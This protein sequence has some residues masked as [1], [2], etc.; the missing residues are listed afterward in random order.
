MGLRCT[1]QWATSVEIR[2]ISRGYRKQKQR[3]SEES[4][5]NNR[6]SLIEKD[7]K[8]LSGLTI[9]KLGATFFP[10]LEHVKGMWLMVFSRHKALICLSP[11]LLL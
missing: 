3:M 7:N 11:A 8:Q 6:K 9:M 10:P 4:S 5:N 2:K 1:M